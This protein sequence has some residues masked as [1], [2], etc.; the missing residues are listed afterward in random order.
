MRLLSLLPETRLTRQFCGGGRRV[1]VA[2]MGPSRG[3]RGD[4]V[5][6]ARPRRPGAPARERVARARA[7]R[8]RER[9]P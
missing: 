9:R 1:P 4:A 3:P 7:I 6:R 8:A 5:A 2:E